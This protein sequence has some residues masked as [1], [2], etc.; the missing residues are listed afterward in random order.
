MVLLLLSFGLTACGSTDE[1][2]SGP[3]PITPGEPITPGTP[4]TPGE[5][6]KPGTPITPGKPIDFS[7]DHDEVKVSSDDKQV[8]IEM[9]DALLF[10]YN[11][12]RL[13]EEAKKVLDEIGRELKKLKQ[14]KVQING[15][16]DSKG[17]D[18]YNLA[19]SEKRAKSVEAYFT[20]A[21]GFSNVTFQT[22][23]Y[24]ETRPAASNDTEEN[25]QK[26]RR[27]EMVISPVQK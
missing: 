7:I 21:G 18:A 14:A 24:G 9:P 3:Q 6:I 26:N 17:D 25:G 19:L 23:G 13:K 1:K 11:D 16:T 20:E 22:K 2:T 5:P 10:D 8:K 27:V 12:S 4:I 15:H